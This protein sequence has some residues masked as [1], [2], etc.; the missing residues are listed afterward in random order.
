MSGQGGI[1]MRHGVFAFCSLMT[2]AAVSG[3]GSC[4]TGFEREYEAGSEVRIRVRSG[5]TEIVGVPGT[6]L[7]VTC[8]FREHSE[9]DKDA[10]IEFDHKG[11]ELR[12]GGGP[13]NDFHA[14]IEVPQRAHLWVRSPAGDLKV[15]GLKVIRI[16]RCMPGSY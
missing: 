3:A 11:G 16:S 14:R 13:S 8:Y 4:A 1:G 12:I 7:K 10:R 9:R 6:K 5:D 15:K 2:M